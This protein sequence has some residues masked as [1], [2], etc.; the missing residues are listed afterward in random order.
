MGN[1]HAEL[2]K[3]RQLRVGEAVA[4]QHN[5]VLRTRLD[6]RDDGA[7]QL[8]RGLSDGPCWRWCGWQPQHANGSAHGARV[9][10]LQRRRQVD[11]F[12]AAAVVA[13]V[14][15]EEEVPVKSRPVEPSQGEEEEEEIPTKEALSLGLKSSQVKV[16]RRLSR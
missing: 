13:K 15:T 9:S 11:E 3:G 7:Q 6:K 10:Y 16:R 1:L 14:W 5:A 8:S 12:V 2:P 4:E